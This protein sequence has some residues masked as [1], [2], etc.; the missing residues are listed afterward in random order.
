MTVT[1]RPTSLTATAAPARPI[2]LSWTRPA[3]TGGSAITSYRIYR[4][5]SS[6]SETYLGSVSCGIGSCTSYHDTS[7]RSGR[8]YYYKVAA[9]NAAGT[10]ALSDEATA[11][12][13]WCQRE[14][15]RDKGAPTLSPPILEDARMAPQAAGTHPLIDA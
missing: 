10:G 3:S 11:V 1:D 15:R 7:T 9:V 6:G 8:H 13:S 12:A 4:S 5:R 14:T 2:D